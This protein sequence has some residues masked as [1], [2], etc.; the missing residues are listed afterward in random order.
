MYS[1]WQ[2]SSNS[3]RSRYLLIVSSLTI[4]AI[5]TVY[6]IGSEFI[7]HQLMIELYSPNDT[8]KRAIVAKTC[9]LLTPELISNQSVEPMN[10]Q[11][12]NGNITLFEDIFAAEKQP[13]LDR[14]IFFI[15][16]SCVR[17]G[18]AALNA[19]QACA[20]ES[21]ARWNPHR[22]IFVLF[23][24][25][26]GF[27]EELS[28]S[29]MKSLRLYQNIYFRRIN[30]RNY[31]MG[32]P[33]E[34]FFSK[35]TI[36]ES[37]YL[38]ETFSDLLRY[39]TLYRFGGIYLDTDSVVQQNLDHLPA[40]FAGKET[41]K[42]VACGAIGLTSDGLGH[43]IAGII[44]KTV[45]DNFNPKIWGNTGPDAI[46]LSLF[47]ICN[48]TKVSEMKPEIC[49]R[50]NVLPEGAFYP[51]PYSQWERYFDA[52]FTSE[53]L[54]KSNKSI[55]VHFWNRLSSQ[56]PILKDFHNETLIKMYLDRLNKTEKNQIPIGKTA[57]GVI[58]KRNCPRAYDSSG[59][60]F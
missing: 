36:F 51:I 4:I 15:E 13:T 16:S 11:S 33:A 57:Y 5:Y 29:T 8:A 56:Q 53:V 47:K 37:E 14:T 41:G 34:K 49:W 6:Q 59:D 39:L 23:A 3:F 44:I 18:L 43:K 21:A 32:T 40:N 28:S 26:V 46:T 20:I 10:F 48:V 22:D 30:F 35:D 38:I 31:S 50:F 25:Q 27:S 45:C 1:K 54:Q 55:A 58:A 42:F 52:R 17:N 19:R 2:V 12:R 24:S 9:F 60:L 7:S